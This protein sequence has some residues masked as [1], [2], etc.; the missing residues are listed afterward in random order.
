MTT[1][2]LHKLGT[3]TAKDITPLV[4]SWDGRILRLRSM[5]SGMT[6][7]GAA[8]EWIVDG[9]SYQQGWLQTGPQVAVSLTR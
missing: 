6:T 9:V 4:T 5:P 2:L 3:K 8:A 7:P 1:V